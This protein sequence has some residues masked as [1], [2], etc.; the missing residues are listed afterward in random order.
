MATITI[1]F[2]DPQPIGSPINV[3]KSR[4]I[5][6]G[7]DRAS[8]GNM[9]LQ[10]KSR[11]PVSGEAGLVAGAPT[12]FTSNGLT[13]SRVPYT[14]PDEGTLRAASFSVKEQLAQLVERGYIE[15][16]LA[17]AIQTATQVRAL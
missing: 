15:V 10:D 9:S 7:A 3:Q 6:R 14:W 8:P 1:R 17:A 4:V 16:L 11:Q 13:I 2:K 5:I 12:D